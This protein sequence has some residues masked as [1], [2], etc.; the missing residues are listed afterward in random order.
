MIPISIPC[1]KCG[2]PKQHRTSYL[3]VPIKFLFFCENEKC[4]TPNGVILKFTSKD[5]IEIDSKF[6]IGVRPLPLPDLDVE[7]PVVDELAELI[8]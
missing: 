5:N 3:E 6:D 2:S 1:K 7:D 4:R 8:E